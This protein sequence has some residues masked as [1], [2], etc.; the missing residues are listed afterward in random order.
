MF[1]LTGDEIRATATDTVSFLAG[2]IDQSQPEKPGDFA[3]S[4]PNPVPY[5]VG[6]AAAAA[7]CD[8][9]VLLA[10]MNTEDEIRELN[11]KHT[12]SGR[13]S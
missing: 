8:L 7:Q 4:A 11:H 13:G 12:I 1:N 10:K 5:S 2:V 9:L 3:A 6:V